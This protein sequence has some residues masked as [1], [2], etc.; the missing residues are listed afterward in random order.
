MK[1]SSTVKVFA[2]SLLVLALAGI[3]V[4][5]PT[6]VSIAP[7]D[8]ARLLAGQK[9]DLR[10]QGRGEGPFYATIA[11]DGVPLEFTSGAQGTTTT[12]GITAAGYGGFNLRGYSNTSP[13]RHTT[14]PPFTHPPGNLNT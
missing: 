11:I 13:G 2:S 14:T 6:N 8:G 1:C 10:I 5:D 3:A 12:D 9:F 4:A 7:P